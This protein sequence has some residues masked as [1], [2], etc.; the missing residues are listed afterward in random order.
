[1][2]L[3]VFGRQEDRSTRL[4]DALADGQ[5]VLEVAD[6]KNRELEFDVTEVAGALGHFLEAG[7]VG[8]FK[9]ALHMM[10]F[11]RCGK[12]CGAVTA[13]LQD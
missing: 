13:Y 2:D 4:A 10:A 1:M 6:V 3:A 12:F 11:E 7:P 8:V 9:Q 5:R